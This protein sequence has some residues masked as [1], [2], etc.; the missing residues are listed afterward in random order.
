MVLG[1][2]RW[3][4]VGSHR[5]KCYQKVTRQRENGT[6]YKNLGPPLDNTNFYTW[7]H[8]P[9]DAS[10]FEA[11]NCQVNLPGQPGR[12]TWQVNLPSQPGRSTCYI[13]LPGQPGRSTW[14]GQPGRSTWQA[15]LAGQPARS[16]WQVN[17]PYIC[18]YVY[19]Y[20][21]VYVY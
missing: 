18:M 14:Q 3:R 20:V 2:L 5:R 19:V 8:F 1:G 12:S 10:L 15:N 9:F 6:M 17:L 11:E 7:C 13:N 16:T 4:G 21:Y